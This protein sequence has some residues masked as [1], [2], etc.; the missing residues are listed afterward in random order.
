MGTQMTR[1]HTRDRP[2]FFS[3]FIQRQDDRLLMKSIANRAARR[4]K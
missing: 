3:F 1:R 2:S 4:K